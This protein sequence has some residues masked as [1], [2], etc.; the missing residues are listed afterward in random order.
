MSKLTA[1]LLSLVLLI[2]CHKQVKA[3]VPVAL[4]PV[5]H[6]QFLSTTGSPLANGI[7]FTYAAGTT[8]LSNTYID[9]T[10][11]SQ[12]TDP[13]IL[14]SGGFA[15]IWLANQSYKF[16]VQDQNGVQQWTV[17]NVSGYLGLLNLANTWTFS[18]IF[19]Q[20]ITITPSDN[21]IILGA[22]GSQATID[23]PP[24]SGGG[25]TLHNQTSQSDTYIYRNSTDTVC[26]KTLTAPVLNNPTVTGTIVG[27]S[28]TNPVINGVGM[29]ESPA[30]YFTR[31]NFG[32]PGTT[33]FTLTKLTGNPSSARIAATTDAGGIVGIAVSGA[34]NSGLV[35]VQQ[36]GQSQCIFDNATS[37]GNYISIS[38]IN[39]G[40][41]HDAGS[42]LPA[43]GQ[44]IG[45]VLISNITAGAINDVLLF[46]S[47]PGNSGV[48]TAHATQTLNNAAITSFAV[49]WS[50]AFTDTNYSATCAVAVNA[51][52]LSAPV[53]F[54]GFVNKSA[55]T[56]QPAF[57]NN[58]G[59]ALTSAEI[60]CLAIHD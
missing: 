59:A 24:A 58:T 10:G 50:T 21:Q 46:G 27:M 14:D 45:R 52:V 17:D 42:A 25:V 33:Q 4:S 51:G 34:G 30:A 31:G 38:S 60:D 8:T 35:T 5:P 2:A 12:N 26:C 20:P 54:Q 28:L 55:S 37:A 39:A 47:D 53:N 6:M 11:T 29:F 43:S 44:V 13:I 41:C 57:Y 49:T 7:V 15:D 48:R 56:A 1:V 40:N 32:S 3:Q 18:Q 19:T 23:A 36:N 16:V 9:S 22:P